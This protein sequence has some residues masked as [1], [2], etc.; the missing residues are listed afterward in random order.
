M[1]GDWGSLG[2]RI[3]LEVLSAF[4]LP[5]HRHLA[6]PFCLLSLKLK[7]SFCF[8][9][10][11]FLMYTHYQFPYALDSQIYMPNLLNSHSHKHLL[12]ALSVDLIVEMKSRMR[13]IHSKK[14][15]EEIFLNWRKTWEVILLGPS[16]CKAGG[17]EER[18]QPDASNL[19]ITRMKTTS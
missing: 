14:L 4:R 5:C 19:R 10:G 16:D 9:S 13:I 18:P 15:L 2:D 1:G 7:Y 6:L 3:S 12:N 8:F 11:I 17:V